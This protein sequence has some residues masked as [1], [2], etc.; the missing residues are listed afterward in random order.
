MGRE[1]TVFLEGHILH[2][3]FLYFL[4]MLVLMFMYS[5]GIMSN[6]GAGTVLEE[7]S[8][9]GN[10][11]ESAI[12]NTLIGDSNESSLNIMKNMIKAEQYVD[13]EVYE[14]VAYSSYITK[15]SNGKAYLIVECDG[16]ATDVNGI[17]T[18][19]ELLGEYYS[20]YVGEQWEDHRTNWD[21]FFVNKDF[22][23]ILWYYLP[24]SE[25]YT[26]SEWRNSSLY[27]RQLGSRDPFSLED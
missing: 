20:V 6:S 17:V 25:V 1:I 26:L 16:R 22:D 21:W 3:F 10:S 12:E 11:D 13:Q 15:K 18:N 24:E 2:K 19:D 8:I 4:T 23:E 27:Y 5:W 14:L 7:T 9:N